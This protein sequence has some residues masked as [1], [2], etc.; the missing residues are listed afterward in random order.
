MVKI[1][2]FAIEVTE[3]EFAAFME[4]MSTRGFVQGGPPAAGVTTDDEGPVNAAAPPV[5]TRGIPHLEAVHASTK[6][7][8][9]EGH[10]RRKKGVTNEQMEQAENAWRASQATQP[11][12]TVPGSITGGA[13]V[14]LANPDAAALPGAG[15]PGA[16]AAT[17]LPG[18]GLPGMTP[19]PK[20]V[21]Y[22]DIAAKYQTLA[23]A[24]KIDQN[25]MG[26][27]Y[28]KHGVTDANIL[29]NNEAVRNALMADLNLLG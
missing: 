15:L 24:G 16:P 25:M 7:I 11:T 29:M 1:I 27:Y 9:A 8:T 13:P 3:A 22:E 12:F 28:A 14:Q 23:N 2:N 26:Q 19:A 17:G 6:G 18:A 20:P 5:D 4:R 10:W 21:T